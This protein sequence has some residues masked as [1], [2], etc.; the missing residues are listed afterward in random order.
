MYM[1]INQDVMCHDSVVGDDYIYRRKKTEFRHEHLRQVMITGFRASKSLV[2]LVIYILE[3][4]PSLE[5]LTLDTVPGYGRGF[6]S[7]ASRTIG[8]C[9]RMSK[10]ALTEAHNAIEVAGRYI[11]GRVPSGVEFQVLEP[12]SRCHSGNP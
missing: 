9:S 4:A 5:R 12:C 3:S 2:E 8:Q 7:C 6:G 11:A 10:T 1:Q